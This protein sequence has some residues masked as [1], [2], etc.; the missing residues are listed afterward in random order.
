MVI[1]YSRS[2]TNTSQIQ[3]TFNDTV[4]HDKKCFLCLISRSC[5]LGCPK[6][7][8]MTLSLIL[9]LK[10]SW[11]Y[12]LLVMSKSVL[13]SQNSRTRTKVLRACAKS[14]LCD[15]A[16]FRLIGTSDGVE[17]STSEYEYEYRKKFRE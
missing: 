15:A 5:D 11:F 16:L 8:H 12:H 2:K 1:F 14:Q 6:L 17:Y 7:A 10:L 9:M 4:Y 13:I 3:Q